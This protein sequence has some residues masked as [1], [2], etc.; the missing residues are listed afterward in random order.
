MPLAVQHSLE[1]LC[2][3]G[4]KLD[5]APVK[6]LLAYKEEAASGGD[7]RALPA[8]RH[9]MQSLMMDGLVAKSL[10]GE[11]NHLIAH[12]TQYNGIKQGR[13]GQTAVPLLLELPTG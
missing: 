6:P 4:A 13:A 12:A 2:L 10:G 3:A 8:G 7:G 1:E 9:K 11:L 5:T